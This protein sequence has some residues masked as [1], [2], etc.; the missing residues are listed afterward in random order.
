M[1]KRKEKTK[2]YI[3]EFVTLKKSVT[4]GYE[5][6]GNNDPRNRK[7]Q[8]FIEHQNSNKIGMIIGGTYRNIGE[9][10]DNY[11]EGVEFKH[12]KRIFVYQIR[13]GFTNKII[14]ALPKY[15]KK[16]ELG[17]EIPFNDTYR[18]KWTEKDSQLAREAVKNQPRDKNGR[19]IK[20]NKE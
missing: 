7:R 19:W 16:S 13:F 6:Y 15:I 17:R 1:I 9:R 12:S 5:W 14:E 3:G 11:P 2:F 8:M 4:F 20:N 18:A 10:I